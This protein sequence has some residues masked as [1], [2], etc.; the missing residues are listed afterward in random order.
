MSHDEKPSGT[1][2]ATIGAARAYLLECARSVNPVLHAFWEAKRHA[3]AGFP[4]I[5]RGAFDAYDHLTGDGK[6]VRA[7]LVRLG[8]EAC[9]HAGSPAPT[10]PDSLD[11]AAGCV[12]ILHNAFLIHDDIVDRSDLRRNAPTVHR[13]Y[14][15]ARRDRFPRPEDALA[16][17]QAVALNFGDKGQALAQELLITSGFPEDVLLP[18]IALLSQVTAETVAGQLLD[19]EDVRLA[20]LSEELVLRIHEYKT[21]HYTIMLPLQMGA[22]LARAD[23]AR[24]PYIRDYAVP[25]GIAFQ[26]QD[27]VL[28][29]YGEETVL[30]K[31]VDSDVKEGKK[32]LLFVH[33][34]ERAAAA[35][36]AFL[37]RAHGN[38]GLRPEDLERVRRIVRESGA[39]ARSEALARELVARG[40]AHIPSVTP[41]PRWQG[42]LAGVGDYLIER[43]Y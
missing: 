39:L 35:D 11:R 9:R 22:I 17:G 27:D 28:G 29:L 25:I 43:R 8:F 33:A 19:V 10:A 14:A 34:Y 12:E 4:E 18:A 6:K 23:S 3:W 30:G 32:T 2:Q 5:V 24:L 36:R 37:E 1:P 16:Y 13:R 20:E 26:I 21:A 41:D 31:P 15:D 7:G 38:A 40:K 42:V